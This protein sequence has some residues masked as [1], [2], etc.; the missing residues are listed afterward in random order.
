MCKVC[1]A[2]AMIPVYEWSIQKILYP[3]YRIQSTEAVA[4][5]ACQRDES[6]I[7]GHSS[8]DPPALAFMSWSRVASHLGDAGLLPGGGRAWMS[9]ATKTVVTIVQ[10]SIWVS[11]PTNGR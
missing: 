3:L 9:A 5:A 8:G 4:L 10:R 2:A 11:Q 6:N 7:C 1:C